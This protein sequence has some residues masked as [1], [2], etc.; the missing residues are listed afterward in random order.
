M[1]TCLDYDLNFSVNW[2]LFLK[3]KSIF[4]KL[5]KKKI[6]WFTRKM[7]VFLPLLIVLS[8]WNTVGILNLLFSLSFTMG[9]I[10]L[11][12]IVIRTTTWDL[13]P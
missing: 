2:E 10:L 13:P 1:V 8:H 12:F 6:N 5:L 7:P 3:V 4:K 11:V 9:N